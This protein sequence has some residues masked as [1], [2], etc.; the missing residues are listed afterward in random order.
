MKNTTSTNNIIIILV[1]LLITLILVITIIFAIRH[2][3]LKS[4]DDSFNKNEIKCDYSNKNQKNIAQKSN[5]TNDSFTVFHILP[6][7]NGTIW[8]LRKMGD[9]KVIKSSTDKNELI[10]YYKNNF[11]LNQSKLF[12][13]NLKGKFFEYN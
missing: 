9:S 8:V 1:T 2:K 12:V 5:S 10:D 11:N 13:H 6:H 4:K 7:S 3:I